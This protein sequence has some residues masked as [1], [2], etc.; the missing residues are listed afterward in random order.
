MRNSALPAET[1][2]QIR[3][4]QQ[5]QRQQQQHP[6]HADRI[7]SEFMVRGASA[8]NMPT[9]AFATAGVAHMGSIATESGL[10]HRH[11]HHH[12]HHHRR[13]MNRGVTPQEDDEETTTDESV[14]SSTDESDS[15]PTPVLKLPSTYYSGISGVLTPALGSDR[16]DQPKRSSFARSSSQR[17]HHNQKISSTNAASISGRSDE[18]GVQR[19]VLMAKHPNADE[20]QIQ[21]ALTKQRQ[22]KMTNRAAAGWKIQEFRQQQQL[23]ELLENQQPG[24]QQP[25]VELPGGHRVAFRAHFSDDEEEPQGRF[26][27]PLGLR[28]GIQY[29]KEG[30]FSN[31]SSMSYNGNMLRRE[32]LSQDGTDDDD[33]EVVW[34]S[35]NQGRSG[36][37]FFGQ[38]ILPPSPYHQRFGSAQGIHAID[39]EQ[40][41]H[42]YNTASDTGRGIFGLAVAFVGKIL[43]AKSPPSM[44]PDE[45]AAASVVSDFDGRSTTT[46]MDNKSHASRLSVPSCSSEKTRKIDNLSPQNSPSTN[47]VDDREGGMVVRYRK[48]TRKEMVLLT[49]ILVL[50]FSVI[51]A[52]ASALGGKSSGSSDSS[53]PTLAEQSTTPA[54]LTSIPNIAFSEAPAISPISSTTQE[55]PTVPPFEEEDS[56]LIPTDSSTAQPSSLMTVE[57]IN[58]ENGRFVT[59]SPTIA[60]DIVAKTTIP[61]PFPTSLLPTLVPTS[62]ATASIPTTTAPSSLPSQMPSDLPFVAWTWTEKGEAIVG[63]QTD[64]GFGQ[65]VALSEDGNT[66]AIGAPYASHNGL[67]QAG[68]VQIFLWNHETQLWSPFALLSGRNAGDQFGS[69]IALSADGTVLA[70]SEPTF[71]GVAG[72]RSGNV[73]VFVRDPF[74][75]FSQL[76]QDLEGTNA[77]DHSGIG[78]SI[79]ANGRRLAVGSPYHTNDKVDAN[80]TDTGNDRVVSGQA[81]IYDWFIEENSWVPVG[82]AV[83][84]GSSHLDWFGW[85]LSLHE[86]GSVICVGAPRNSEF[87]GY[88]LCYEDMDMGNTNSD[89]QLLGDVIRNDRSPIRYDDNFG[90]AVKVSH[91]PTTMNLRVAIGSP[92][93]NGAALDSGIVVVY[94]YQRFSSGVRQWVQLGEAIAAENPSIGDQMGMS[95][96]LRGNVLAIG[97]PGEGTAG[98]VNLYHFDSEPGSGFDKRWTIHPQMFQGDVGATYGNSIQLTASGQ[99]VVGSGETGDVENSGTVNIY[100]KVTQKTT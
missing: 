5:Q 68:M 30:S 97:S 16:G 71:N 9:N 50:T 84:Y 14:L 87:G 23:R 98:K 47:D 93:K 17:L 34:R 42:Q 77:A 91:D 43:P 20:E 37:A 29:T 6:N 56:D 2:N 15:S 81:M 74:N 83:L 13:S 24:Q 88:V 11:H 100:R 66:L 49:L 1:A 63:N 35:G 3:R 61:T 53:L 75:G 72:N 51:V 27:D 8:S 21:E 41:R 70:V 31:A 73:R 39:H 28:S 12:H 86:N 48:P 96:D 33:D 89:W 19:L 62:L 38:D 52:L 80:G 64:Q 60:I 32:S 25:A 90:S 95:V 57:P 54:G 78:L 10:F 40:A 99:L 46:A 69:S 67:A 92:G 85:S 58:I 59:A 4:Q 45:S 18:D 82:G 44:I 94:E 26:T 55:I 76:G 22:Q 79:S 36:V 65:S 7:A